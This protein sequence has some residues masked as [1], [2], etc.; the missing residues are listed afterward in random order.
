MSFIVD[1]ERGGF[2][3][4]SK[5]INSASKLESVIKEADKLKADTIRIY[6]IRIIPPR[7]IV[8]AKD[9]NGE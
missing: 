3:V 1:F 7:L 5:E 6:D 2:K 9:K 8:Y 4:K